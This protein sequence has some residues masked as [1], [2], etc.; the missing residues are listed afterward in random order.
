MILSCIFL[1]ISVSIDALS[2][3]ITYGIKKAKINK[4]ANIIVFL[5]AFISTTIS[6]LL[7]SGISKL[8][9]PTIATVLGSSLLILLGIYTIHKSFGENSIDYDFDDSN[10]I[11]RKEAVLLALS[12]SAD[13]SCVGL[14]CGIMGINSLIYPF[15]AALFHLFFINCG[16]LLATSIV[17]RIHISNRILSIFSGLVLIF[18]GF[19][20]LFL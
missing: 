1:A 11:E 6:I 12:V 18:I 9:S 19:I 13:A 4:V 3:G 17:N 14:S 2:L 16:N 8:F 5:I 7:G 20:R 10:S 15:L